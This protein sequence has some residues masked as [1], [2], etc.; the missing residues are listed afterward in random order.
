MED[1]NKKQT[2]I[3]FEQSG[4]PV[5][6]ES[7]DEEYSYGMLRVRISKNGKRHRADAVYCPI[8]QEEAEEI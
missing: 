5:Y 8:C 7:C 3:E 4:S 2:R 1:G 6:C